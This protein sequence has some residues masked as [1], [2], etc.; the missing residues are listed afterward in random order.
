MDK[1]SICSRIYDHDHD[2][3]RTILSAIIIKVD[4]TIFPSELKQ[5]YI[6]THIYIY[7]SQGR[8]FLFFPHDKMRLLYMYIRKTNF[9]QM[10]IHFQAH[11]ALERKVNKKKRISKE[12]K[13]FFCRSV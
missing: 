8:N 5:C 13:F 12:K 6:V 2:H 3:V 9:N 7:I 10:I 1:K 11:V 4:A